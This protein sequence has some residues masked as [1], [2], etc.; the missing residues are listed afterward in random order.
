MSKVS[1]IVCASVALA[2]AQ[3]P[4]E[5]VE[6]SVT[7]G[8]DLSEL[9]RANRELAVLYFGRMERDVERFVTDVYRP[10]II[11]FTMDD[12]DIV[13]KI[14]RASEPES[15]LDPVDIMEIY[16]DEVLARFDEFRNS[17]LGP[18]HAQEREVLTS[19]D[20]AYRQVQDANS[21][22][23][24]H[25]ASVRKVHDAQAE[26]LAA[27]GVPDLR[28]T[29]GT[30]VAALSDSVAVLLER[31]RGIKELLDAGKAAVA[32]S[33]LQSLIEGVSG[34]SSEQ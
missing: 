33:V 15:E 22:V 8:R 5:A 16:A 31:A 12:L 21:V 29:V 1:I 14:V 9:H 10:Y 2:C 3:V 26:Y 27:A 25:L 19:I 30:S 20:V 34:L 28:E 13:N 18:I 23:T 32:D 4:Q 24:G 17:L 11:K 7:V 6:L